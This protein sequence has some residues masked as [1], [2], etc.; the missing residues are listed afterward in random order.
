MKIDPSK[1]YRTRSGRT[2]EFLHRAP[3]GWPGSFPWR[4]IVAGEPITWMENGSEFKDSNESADDLVEVREPMRVKLW[5][6]DGAR[7]IV[8]VLDTELNISKMNVLGYTLKE[9]VEVLP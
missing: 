6:K 3:E 7:P 1:K 4:G 2:V 5:I 9:F 8:C